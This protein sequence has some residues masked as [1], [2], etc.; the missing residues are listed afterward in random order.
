[1]RRSARETRRPEFLTYQASTSIAE[2]QSDSDHNSEPNEVKAKKKRER[3]SAKKEEI[4][5]EGEEESD[6]EENEPKVKRP[7]KKAK[8]A[9]T[10]TKDKN[11]EEEEEERVRD[12]SLFGRRCNQIKLI[13]T[14]ICRLDSVQ[15][16]AGKDFSSLCNGWLEKH[17]VRLSLLLLL[18]LMPEPFRSPLYNRGLS[19]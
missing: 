7:T 15:T 5:G 18:R 9:A 17:Q 4:S 3:S 13:S 12:I 14:L 6:F 10:N 1:M 19:S 11:A 2:D 8:K 16:F